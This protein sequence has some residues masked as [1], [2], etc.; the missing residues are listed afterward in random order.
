[1]FQ[2]HVV[3]SENPPSL[4]ENL[5]MTFFRGEGTG[6]KDDRKSSR[7]LLLIFAKEIRVISNG[8]V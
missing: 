4:L 3:K 5:W 8:R 7:G 6:Y 2:D 1:M